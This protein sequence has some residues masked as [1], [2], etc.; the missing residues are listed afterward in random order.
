MLSRKSNQL[1]SCTAVS[2]KET[3]TSTRWLTICRV[4][5]RV[6]SLSL[7]VNEYTLADDRWALGVAHESVV[8]A[9]LA[10][11][12]LAAAAVLADLDN[13]LLN[14]LR[15]DLASAAVQSVIYLKAVTAAG[16]VVHVDS[17]IRVVRIA[18]A[19][20]LVDG[21][22]LVLGAAHAYLYAVCRE[23]IAA[24][25]R[26]HKVRLFLYNVADRTAVAAAMSHADKYF[27][28]HFLLLLW[29]FHVR[30]ALNANHTAHRSA[31]YS[32][33][34]RREQAA[35]RRAIHPRAAACVLHEQ[36][37]DVVAVAD[38]LRHL[39]LGVARRGLHMNISTVCQQ[40]AHI[41]AAAVGFT[42]SAGYLAVLDGQLPAADRIA[43]TH[44]SLFM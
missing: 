19:N 28:A 29:N 44:F 11:S 36:Q 15:E 3:A 2:D 32:L 20:L 13:L 6:F 22:L 34:F 12:G 9:T 31:V 42:E 25:Q 4:A 1:I 10:L 7:G 37:L 18:L 38:V 17:K 5:L 24:R 35:V 41:S 26:H 40:T 23:V 14:I 39:V 43:G 16:V 33:F 8:I 30:F 21:V 27:L